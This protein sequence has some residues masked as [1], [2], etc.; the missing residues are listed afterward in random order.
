MPPLVTLSRSHTYPSQRISARLSWPALVSMRG[1][2]EVEGLR[3]A[4]PASSMR[5]EMSSK[6]S[7]MSRLAFTETTPFS[8]RSKTAAEPSLNLESCTVGFS[9]SS[10]ETTR[11]SWTSR[12]AGRFVFVLNT[13][14]LNGSILLCL[15]LFSSTSLGACITNVCR[16]STLAT[17]SA[18]FCVTDRGNPSSRKPFALQSACEMRSITTRTASSSGTGR[19]FSM[20]AAAR[21][22]SSVAYLTCARRSSPV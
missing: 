17:L 12:L 6:T 21:R 16:I 7:F 13:F 2:A 18:S 20:K 5:R 22:P 15:I 10:W 14:P 4:M 19:S 11:R 3:G 8:S 1:W 9:K